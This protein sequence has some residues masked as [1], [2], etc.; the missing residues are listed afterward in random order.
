VGTRIEVKHLINSVPGRRKFLKTD[1]TEAAHIIQNVRL[2]ALAFP[3]VAFTLIEDGRI[4][5]RSPQSET[6]A[7]RVAGIFGKQIA[8]NLIP[9]DNAE[10]GMRISGLIDRPGQGMGRATRHEM[11]TYINRRPV[12]SRALNY[13]LI[14]SYTEH[15]PKGRYPV[16]FVFFEIDPASVDVNVH[17]AKREVR[18]RNEQ[19][20][21]SFV[22]RSVL[23]KL[24]EEQGGT[25]QSSTGF[26]PVGLDVARASSPCPPTQPYPQIVTPAPVQSQ[27]AQT[28]KP[29]G[30]KPVLPNPPNP[31]ASPS[32]GLEARATSQSA[33]QVEPP[34]T[35]PP[36]SAYFIAL[37]TMRDIRIISFSA[38][39]NIL[40][41]VG[42][43]A[44]KSSISTTF[45]MLV[46]ITVSG[47]L[48]SWLIS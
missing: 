5:F 29:M 45:M 18:F 41:I 44:S 46:D 36:A 8:E 13:A 27:P 26:Q 17:P 38:L 30:W 42:L 33:S 3:H 16:A 9:I 22:I 6:L 28:A 14:E 34:P 40:C 39:P 2:Y 1:T 7:A 23:A 25:A 20:V 24:R 11:I 32:H 10:N 21:R 43:S 47:V 48:K 4:I 15:L 37:S 12:D 31:A 19:A 35:L